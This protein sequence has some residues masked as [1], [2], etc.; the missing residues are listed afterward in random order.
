MFALLCVGL[1][2]STLAGIIASKLIGQ[3]NPGPASAG[4]VGKTAV[5]L[6]FATTLF[7]SYGPLGAITAV[8]LG[9][10][11]A[12]IFM[13]VARRNFRSRYIWYEFLFTAAFFALAAGMSVV[14]YALGFGVS[15]VEIIQI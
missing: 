5:I 13:A 3:G 1:W 10:V 9:D 11:A 6:I 14:R 4:N 8:V 12:Y 2:F 15:I 7:T